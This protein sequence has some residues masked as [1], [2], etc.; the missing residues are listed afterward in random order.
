MQRQ[1]SAPGALPPSA[2][3]AVRWGRRRERLG[4]GA[5]HCLEGWTWARVTPGAGECVA[6][7]SSHG[8]NGL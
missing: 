2:L 7:A 6:L 1:T 4:A 5:A 8:V 3:S